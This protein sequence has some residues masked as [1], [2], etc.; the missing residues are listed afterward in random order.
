MSEGECLRFPALLTGKPFFFFLFKKCA[1]LGNSLAEDL[2]LVQLALTA[3][4]KEVFLASF[5]IRYV[6]G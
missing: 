4:D 5:L 6:P 2:P 1:A 3:I